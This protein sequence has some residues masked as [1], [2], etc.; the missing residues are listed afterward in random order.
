[1]KNDLEEI[2]NKFCAYPS[3]GVSNYHEHFER[4]LK[5]NYDISERAFNF[6]NK[7]PFTFMMVGSDARL[8]RG[9]GSPIELILLKK[10]KPKENVFKEIKRQ[11]FEINEI[12]TI[13]DTV[14][15][16][17]NNKKLFPTRAIDS[18]YCGGD[19]SF[20][21]RYK[22][23]MLYELKENWKTLKEDLKNK[24]RN[25]KKIMLTGK[26]KFKGKEIIHYDLEEGV[27]YCNKENFEL[28]FKIG[29][30][31]YIQTKI[32]YETLKYFKEKPSLLEAIK[33]PRNIIH[34]IE[35]FKPIS[36]KNN[37]ELDEVEDDYKYFLNL[38]HL[39]EI[40]YI[41]NKR[42]FSENLKYKQD[43]KQNFLEGTVNFDKKEVKER[44]NS[45][46]TILNNDEILDFK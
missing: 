27:T 6:L 25:Y 34:R 30:L 35:Y 17:V 33:I 29:P 22:E 9:I 5:Y 43:S 12:K 13:D 41:K 32:A 14:F 31:R 40:S 39:C 20:Y 24:I 15:Q 2:L 3:D 11:Y 10:E 19:Y 7:Y 1:M 44:I 26:N 23:K 16:F 28:S 4:I 45:I 42:N 38:Y 8:E 37:F 46:L 18:R 36:K 21:P